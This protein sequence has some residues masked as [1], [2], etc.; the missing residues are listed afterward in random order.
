ILSALVA[1]AGIYTPPPRLYY[2]LDLSHRYDESEAEREKIHNQRMSVLASEAMYA[3]IVKIT[4]MHETNLRDLNFVYKVLRTCRELG[5]LELSLRHVGCVSGGAIPF[6]FPF[7]GVP[8]RDSGDGVGGDSDGDGLTTEWLKRYGVLSNEEWRFPPL[9]KLKLDGYDLQE[10]SDGGYAWYWRDY[11]NYT[12]EWNEWAELEDEEER[13]PPARPVRMEDD[14]ITSLEMWLRVM[15]WSE[16]GTLELSYASTET[17]RLLGAKGVL[18]G[19]AHLVLRR[20]KGADVLGFLRNV[21]CERGCLQS[22]ELRGVDFEWTKEGVAS[23]IEIL[24]TRHPEL[25]RFS[26]GDGKENELFFPTGSLAN[27]THVLPLLESIDVDLPRPEVEDDGN[28]EWDWRGFD[29]VLGAKGLKELTI[30]LPSPDSTIVGQGGVSSG[31]LF[32]QTRLQYRRTGDDLD[33]CDP[34]VNREAVEALFGELRR[35]K[36]GYK[37]EVIELERL[38]GPV[39]R[40]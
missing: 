27:L 37:E 40:K 10:N 17:L 38:P 39:H 31:E 29:A 3:L 5:L 14:G 19:L 34:V 15:D 16:L 11:A 13:E 24:A 30:R 26:V 12:Q 2:T 35:R 25:K 22:L 21:A 36:R 4:Y 18:S 1:Q 20:G 8:A 23:L 9:S 6:A 32:S 33:E 7:R 28:W